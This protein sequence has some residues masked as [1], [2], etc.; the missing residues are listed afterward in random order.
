MT[1]LVLQRP[2]S[3]TRSLKEVR[4]ALDDW[5]N[6]FGTVDSDTNSSESNHYDDVMD[7]V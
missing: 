4:L 2:P 6:W 1:N 3:P 5:N 7:D